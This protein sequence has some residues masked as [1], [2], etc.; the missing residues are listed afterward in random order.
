MIQ[1]L[2]MQFTGTLNRRRAYAATHPM[3][4]EA[5]ERLLAIVHGVLTTGEA[6]SIG[7]ARSE[8][9]INGM[10][11][12]TT[13]SFARDLAQRLH[14]RGVGAVL[15]EPTV[16]IEQLRAAMAW[17]ASDPESVADT[18]PTHD[19]MRIT[20]LEYEHLVLDE[21][22]RNTSNAVVS[23]WRTLADL[24]AHDVKPRDPGGH[25]RPGGAEPDSHDAGAVSV[26]ATTGPGTVPADTGTHSM[27]SAANDELRDALAPVADDRVEGDV[28]VD[29]ID[30]ESVLAKLR[31]SVGNPAVAHKAAT[32]LLQLATV[33]R[34]ASPEVR[35]DIG[36]QLHRTLQRLGGSSFAPIIRSLADRA[37]RRTFVTQVVEVLPVGAVVD[38]LTAAATADEQQMSHQVLRLMAKMSTLTQERGDA[39]TELHFRDAAHELVAGWALDDPNPAEHVE[40]LDRIASFERTGFSRDAGQQRALDDAGYALVES[41]RLVQMALEI[42]V[43]GDDTAAAAEAMVAAGAGQQLMHYITSSPNSTTAQR[44]QHIATSEKAVRITLLSEPVDRLQAR[45]LLELLDA[46]S[47]ATLV[48]VLEEASTRGTR[49]IVRQRLAEFGEAIEPLLVARLEHAHW[50]LIRNILT[51]LLEIAVARGG[52][53]S[54]SGFMMQL[55]QHE[56]AQVRVEALRVLLHDA[57]ARDAALQIALLDDAERVVQLA[58][59]SVAEAADAGARLPAP[60]VTQLMTIV[61][62][63]AHGDTVRARAVRA[64]AKVERDDVRDW[65]LTLVARRSRFL[66]RLTL[67]EPTQTAI[68]ALQV[69]RRVHGT[70]PDVL[71]LVARV[72]RTASDTRWLQKDTWGT[73]ERSA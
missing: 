61:N 55:L 13:G 53:A 11:Y 28:D 52:I 1:Q 62:A 71:Q 57:G 49:M 12:E 5:E 39:T 54:A 9:L 44:L 32:A 30:T 43:A 47:A 15:L 19:G 70:H 4:R 65:M 40:L 60:V 69:L 31:T 73:T 33:G 50:F 21:E 34:Q 58:V 8:L 66:R 64:L 68:S 26:G 72:T 51:L 17:L 25:E 22:A 63:G 2:L 67:A 35:D 24:A 38:W 41:A 16:T 45:A 7:V 36:R 29:D 27:R 37:Q 56:Q 18:P 42:D 20:T 48:D 59:Q 23:L 10:P 14:R 3:V 46:S 6:L